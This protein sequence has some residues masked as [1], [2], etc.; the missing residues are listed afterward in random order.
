MRIATIV[1]GSAF[2][3]TAGGKLGRMALR[4]LPKSLVNSLTAW[5]RTR[6]LPDMPAKSFRAQYLGTKGKEVR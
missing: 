3:F 5:G 2:L 6:D 1:L 4:V